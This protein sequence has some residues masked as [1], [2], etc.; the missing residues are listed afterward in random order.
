[1]SLRVRLQSFLPARGLAIGAKADNFFFSFSLCADLSA[2]LSLP[3]SLCP[4]QELTHSLP[5]VS[6]NTRQRFR[7][8]GGKIRVSPILIAGFLKNCFS[9]ACYI[10]AT[11]SWVGF[12]PLGVHCFGPY[13]SFKIN[14]N[15]LNL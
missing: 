14:F 1:M 4:S 9:R 10:R 5:R 13:Q 2:S 8:Y 7:V 6:A 12:N 11:A 3:I 15:I